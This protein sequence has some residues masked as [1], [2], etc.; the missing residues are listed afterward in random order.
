MALFIGSFTNRIDRKGRVSVP[1]T[2]RSELAGQR[3]NGVVA[4][5]SVKH[6]AV[7]CAGLDWFEQVNASLGGVDLFSDAHDDLTATL[8]A[9]ARQLP[10]DGEGR[11]LLP[12][13]LVAQAR[14]GEVAHFV[15][16][17]SHFE[18]WHP[19]HFASYNAAARQRALDKG[20]T[21]PRREGPK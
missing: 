20:R 12:E 4:F 3:F 5:R 9:D 17:G 14:L 1:V 18:I 10:F 2:F 11:V 19:E 7:H 21:L 13:P 6:P 16:R 8:F 15:G